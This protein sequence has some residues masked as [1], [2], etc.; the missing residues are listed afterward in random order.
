MPTM[1]GSVGAVNDAPTASSAIR[2]SASACS[3]SPRRSSDM[4]RQQA[5]EVNPIG[6]LARRAQAITWSR[7]ASACAYSPARLRTLQVPMKL[8]DSDGSSPRA[9]RLSS[10]AEASAATRVAGSLRT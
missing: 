6:V 8:G 3:R 4:A 9:R 5:A 2:A 10:D 1:P 7:W